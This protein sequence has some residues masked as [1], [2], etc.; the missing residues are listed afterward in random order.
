MS[1]RESKAARAEREACI[2]LLC[3]A[4]ARGLPLLSYKE[5]GNP[6]TSPF[7]PANWRAYFRDI[8]AGVLPGLTNILHHDEAV[9]G[10]VFGCEAILL[11]AR[12]QK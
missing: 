10:E 3:E 12:G 7:R 5:R 11:H 6:K 4:C 8:E 2:K 9:G 1:R